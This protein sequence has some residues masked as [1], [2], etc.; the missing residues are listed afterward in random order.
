MLTVEKKTKLL[1]ENIVRKNWTY[2]MMLEGFRK[3]KLPKYSYKKCQIGRLSY[4]ISLIKLK[5]K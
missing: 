1:G 5:F 2:I 3:K 4:N